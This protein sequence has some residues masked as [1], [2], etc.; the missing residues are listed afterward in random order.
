MKTNEDWREMYM[1]TF[2]NAFMLAVAAIALSGSSFG[3]TAAW[4]YM[5]PRLTGGEFRIHRACVMPAEAKL[6]KLGMKGHEGMSKESDAWSATLQAVVESH[7]KNAG[8]DILPSGMSPDELEK[9]DELQQMVVKLQ[10]R[11]NSVLT[12]IQRHPKDTRKSR[13]TVG[14]E[15]TLLPCAATA[16]ALVYVNGQGQVLTGGKKAFGLIVGGPATSTGFVAVS[17][18]DA[19]SGDVLAYV[20]LFNN[21]AFV[22]DSEKAYGKRLDKVFKQMKIG[23]N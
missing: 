15:V 1:K 14:D 12:Q 22:D 23:A 19:K 4:S 16:D 7:L 18:V 11:Y 20:R 5:Q 17:L 2:A 21:G 6:A 8:I 13:F 10:E 9:N 3:A